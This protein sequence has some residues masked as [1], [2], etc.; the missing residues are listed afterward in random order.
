MTRTMAAPLVL[1]ALLSGCAARTPADWVGVREVTPAFLA[2]RPALHPALAADA[3]G[4]VALTWVTRDSSGANLWLAVSRDTGLTFGVPVRVNPAGV[5]SFPENRPIA[6]FGADGRLAIAWCQPREGE[7][8]AADIV[9]RASGDGGA[10]LGPPAVV[11]DDVADRKPTYHGFPALAF[12]P[13]GAL[14]AVWM[15][16][17]E[18]RRKK[19]ASAQEEES[20]ASLFYATS[21][22]G[23]QSWSDNR[24]LT[25]RACP[26][27]RAAAL[28]DA[29]GRIAVA[30]RAAGHD[31]RDP[32][33]AVAENLDRG[34]AVDT[35]LSADGWHLEACPAVGPGIT[36]NREGGGH[37]VWYTEAGVPGVYVA[38]W[39]PA[40]GLA[41][42]RRALMDSLLDATHPHV[43][44]LGAATLVA[45][46]ARPRADSTH[47][48]LAVRALDPDGT[49]TPWAFLGVG[50][51][52]G[53]VAAVSDRAALA[54]WG[55]KVDGE[56]RVRVARLARR[57]R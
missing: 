45:V 38:P 51:S 3:H 40:H 47:T 44:A 24:R 28:A 9:V 43:A 25:D 11:N 7:P 35:V 10:T 46:E 2:G 1:A 29:K 17:R 18:A 4:R 27:C 36:W 37:Y 20:S 50:V 12:L 53:W 14:F 32:A 22:D 55:E 16:E 31:L 15:D 54:C 42:V 49:V 8:L 56:P 57:G 41:G 48:V 23:G 6:V 26:C 13:D 21:G 52:A 30:Y 5:A 19:R 33:L 34:F 39:R